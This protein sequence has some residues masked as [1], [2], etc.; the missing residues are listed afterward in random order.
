MTKSEISRIIDEFDVSISL[1]N[2]STDYNTDPSEVIFTLTNGNELILLFLE[3]DECIFTWRTKEGAIF[4]PRDFKVMFP[5][6]IQ[7]VPVLGP[8]EHEEK[9]IS[10]DTVKSNLNSHRASRNFRNYWYYFPD[11][12]NEF[13]HKIEETWT[14]MS[15]KKPEYYDNKLTMFCSENRIDRE[16]FW[17]GFG[18]Q[19]WCQLL[20]HLSRAREATI[21]VID[22]PEIYLHP[23]VQRQLMGILRD[24]G[25]DV[26]IATHSV[27]ILS[28][29]EP[30]E[31]LLVDKTKTSALRLKDNKG[32]QRAIDFIGSTHNIT[33]AQLARTRKMLFVE[34]AN[35]YKIIRKIAKKLGF[36]EL[37]IGNDITQFES[38]GFSSWK[39]I[40]S[41]AKVIDKT[42]DERLSIAIVFDRD[43]YCDEEINDIIHEFDEVSVTCIVHNRK[44]IENY[45]LDISAIVKAINTGKNKTDRESVLHILTTA[46][47]NCKIQAQSQYIAKKTSYLLKSGKDYS[48]LT[49]EAITIFE[50]RWNNLETRIEI[51]PGKEI[52]KSVRDTVQSQ[53]C[54]TLT[55]SRII[56]SMHINDIP[57][58]L[59]DLCLKLEMFRKQKL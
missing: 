44:E 52:L 28:D 2:V 1:E 53:Y 9:V 37:S 13:Q 42:L 20:T 27:E 25:S 7:V 8:L 32:I 14:D 23:D 34:G 49:S 15:I 35:D 3:R 21:I 39:E 33:L 5:I 30:N 26:L 31:V 6:N 11:D 50:K 18:F 46:T 40:K 58:D 38:G 4:S 56:E 24:I 36:I 17:A 55:E 51:V 47:D 59:R 54:Y 29:A 45:L 41:F 22:E 48:T 16:I 10:L 57:C 43:Y 19:I 12:W